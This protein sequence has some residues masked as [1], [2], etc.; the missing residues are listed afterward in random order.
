MMF[1]SE[2]FAL[3]FIKSVSLQLMEFVQQIFWVI[4][5]NRQEHFSFCLNNLFSDE[6]ILYASAIAD[7]TR[8]PRVDWKSI[9]DYQIP[10]PPENLL[11]EF[12]K[13]TFPFYDAIIE[14]N[15]ESINLAKIRDLLLPKLINGDF[16]V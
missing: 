10:I 1:Y 5:P 13:L 16:E 6:L 4:T 12:N 7:G 14:T 2:N 15:Q 11:F 8:M 3:I 9:S